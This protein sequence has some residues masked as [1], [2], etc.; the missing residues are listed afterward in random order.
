MNYIKY[1]ENVLESIP[2]GLAKASYDTGFGLTIT[3]EH[4]GDECH[5]FDVRTYEIVRVKPPSDDDP[6]WD[7]SWAMCKRMVNEYIAKSINLRG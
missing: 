5:A 4:L 3:S 1:V 2:K 7:K 6:N